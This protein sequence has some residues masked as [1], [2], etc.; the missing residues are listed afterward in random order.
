MLFWQVIAVF[1]SSVRARVD[2]STESKPFARALLW[3]WEVRDL[4]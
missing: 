3:Q 2:Y 4:L 1:R